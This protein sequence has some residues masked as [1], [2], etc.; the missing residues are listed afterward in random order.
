MLQEIEQ[1]FWATAK[2]HRTMQT[3]SEWRD[4]IQSVQENGL[5][6]RT[7]LIKAA[8]MSLP[9]TLS[10]LLEQIASDHEPPGKVEELLSDASIR[11]HHLHSLLSEWQLDQL[12][13]KQTQRLLQLVDN[14]HSELAASTGRLRAWRMGIFEQL[15]YESSQSLFWQHVDST[16]SSHAAAPHSFQ[17]EHIGQIEHRCAH[18][19]VRSPSVSA[20]SLQAAAQEADAG[21][22]QVARLLGK[23]ADRGFK[24]CV[25]RVANTSSWSELSELLHCMD[26]TRQLCLSSHAPR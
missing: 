9:I 19:R 7:Q 24:L 5:L 18:L 1:V 25:V 14:L 3:D 15:G 12:S 17:R 16:T 10:Q 6:P 2:Q 20:S 8:T 21:G 22:A 23:C 26:A 4:F 11:V 13:E